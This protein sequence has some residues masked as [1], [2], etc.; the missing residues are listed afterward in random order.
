MIIKNLDKYLYDS[1]DD[2]KL[3][4]KLNLQKNKLKHISNNQNFKLEQVFLQYGQQTTTPK[5]HPLKN[6]KFKS[7]P[8]TQQSFETLSYRVKQSDALE[9]INK[10]QNNKS[11]KVCVYY[12]SHLKNSNQSIHAIQ[13]PHFLTKSLQ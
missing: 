3:H 12:H 13:T 11:I 10:L 5:L 2:F 1:Q 6:H 9:I 4:N 7:I 8:P